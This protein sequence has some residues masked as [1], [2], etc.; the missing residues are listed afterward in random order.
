MVGNA[1]YPRELDRHQEAEHRRG[2]RSSL[3]EFVR[4][5]LDERMR[6]MDRQLQEQRRLANKRC[7]EEDKE[8]RIVRGLVYAR[9]DRC[10]CRVRVVRSTTS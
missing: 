1:D 9:V 10:I 2:F 6:G 3:D 4:S 8:R 7:I 5:C